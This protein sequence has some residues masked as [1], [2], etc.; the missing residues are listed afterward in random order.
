[1]TDTTETHQLKQM[2]PKI[3]QWAKIW[4]Y[5]AERAWRTQSNLEDVRQSLTLGV[6]KAIRTHNPKQGPLEAYAYSCA[7]N[8]LS[9][10]FTQSKVRAVAESARAGEYVDPDTTPAD[11]ADPADAIA[12]ADFKGFLED[13]AENTQHPKWKRM[14]ALRARGK[15]LE[16]I[17]TQFACTKQNVDL[18]IRKY[19]SHFTRLLMNRYP[20]CDTLT[21][22]AW[23][24]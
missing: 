7:R 19:G 15:S 11:Y 9:R 4:L 12:L 17:G 1:M 2:A 23:G 3:H 24:G 18:T 21:S 8:E 13:L 22:Q 16:Y 10:F 20:D 5:R 14:C 6:L